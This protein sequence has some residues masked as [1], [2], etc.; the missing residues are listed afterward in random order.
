MGSTCSTSSAVSPESRGQA[1]KRRAA[2]S[3]LAAN[4]G[5]QGSDTALTRRDASRGSS[6]SHLEHRSRS[7]EKADEANP[8]AGLDTFVR[9]PRSNSALPLGVLRHDAVLGRDWVVRPGIAGGFVLAPS[10][11]APPRPATSEGER[12]DLRPVA[13]HGSSSR[14]GSVSPERLSRRDS[15]RTSVTSR[16][17]IPSQVSLL[18]RAP[19]RVRG[20]LQ[21]L[22]PGEGKA[23]ALP[24][25]MA[26]RRSTFR[27]TATH[28]EQSLLRPPLGRAEFRAGGSLRAS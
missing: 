13:R 21:P 25:A 4:T 2:Y 7:A 28:T 26:H 23:T 3:P 27:P 19:A 15:S 18:P 11:T 14:N 9:R 6:D 8:K 16:G 12:A 20:S 10:A 24:S 17:S 1:I 22:R 5:L